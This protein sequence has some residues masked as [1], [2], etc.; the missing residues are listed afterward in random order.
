MPIKK[1]LF[2]V[3]AF[4]L[5]NQ[6]AWSAPK[7]IKAIVLWKDKKEHTHISLKRLKP[8]SEP[9]RAILSVYAMGA[10]FGDLTEALG[11]TGPKPHDD[12]RY[13]RCSSAIKK[14]VEKWF[15]RNG[16][17]FHIVNDVPLFRIMAGAPVNEGFLLSGGCYIAPM[18]ATYI[19]WWD[20]ISVEVFGNRVRVLARGSWYLRMGGG[21]FKFDTTYQ[22]L[23]HK[24]NIIHH[25]FSP[26]ND[27]FR[28][29]E[30]FLKKK[31]IDTIFWLDGH[32]IEDCWDCP[33][34]IG[35]KECKEG[36]KG[37]GPDMGLDNYDQYYT[38]RRPV[39]LLAHK[40][41]LKKYKQG[42]LKS[43][44]KIMSYGF[45]QYES[46]FVFIPEKEPDFSFTSLEKFRKNAELKGKQLLTPQELT[47]MA[48]DY[49]FF[50]AEAGKNEQ[51]EK[52]LLQVIAYAPK[53]TVA[54]LNL[55][56][57]LWKLGKK[58]DA[59]KYYKKYLEL[60]GKKK[61]NKAPVRVKER[62]GES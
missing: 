36:C 9:L 3:I 30:A 12:N 21:D 43:A 2:L 53:R 6:S 31:D 22:I 27:Y 8:L 19:R 50:L 39:V 55:G 42:K 58:N 23:K 38:M 61:L 29:K 45:Y 49:A 44:V 14:L 47:A 51:A 7:K 13:L 48:N 37:G 60:V 62:M 16:E 33:A 25:Q 46:G 59:R 40:A 52:L 34:D 24:I 41:A 35:F 26:S 17:P 57:V 18:E 54:Y 56:D 20:F 11:F 4:L 10:D 1:F 15:A 32:S 5:F 28:K